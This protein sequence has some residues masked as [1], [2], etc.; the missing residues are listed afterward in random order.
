MDKLL[1]GT[2]IAAEYHGQIVTV[3]IM[4]KF[5]FLYRVRILTT[6]G[7]YHLGWVPNWHIIYMP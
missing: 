2:S 3:H 7:T 1:P 5:M 6:E 4:R